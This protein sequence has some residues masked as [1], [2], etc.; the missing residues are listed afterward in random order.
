MEATLG[1]AGGQQE[2]YLERKVGILERV[3][4]GGLD[5]KRDAWAKTWKKGSEPCGPLKKECK[6]KDPRWEYALCG[7]ETVGRTGKAEQSEW[8]T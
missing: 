5:R 1:E 2:C 6:G 3:V 7:P 8:S 4:A